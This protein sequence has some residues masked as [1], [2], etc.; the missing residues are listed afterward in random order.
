MYQPWFNN[1]FALF[2]MNLLRDFGSD[3]NSNI[4]PGLPH[5]TECFLPYLSVMVRRSSHHPAEDPDTLACV[6][7]DHRDSVLNVLESHLALDSCV[8]QL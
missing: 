1:F 5:S 7:G 6:G 4:F 8:D 2:I 3:L